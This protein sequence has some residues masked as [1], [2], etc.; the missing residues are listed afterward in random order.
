[1]VTL[2]QTQNGGNGNISDYELNIILDSL[3]HE[4][5]R[6]NKG[7]ELITNPKARQAVRAAKNE[8]LTVY[9]T[10]CALVYDPEADNA[11]T[12]NK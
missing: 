12:G 6:Y 3:S 5:E 10:L 2:Q 11:Q 8:I 4:M 7:E 9:K 1:M